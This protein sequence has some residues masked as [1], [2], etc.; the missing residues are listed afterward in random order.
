M[1]TQSQVLGPLPEHLTVV[2]WPD[3][4]ADGFGHA[5]DS[6]TWRRHG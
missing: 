4:V 5:P 1:P 3:A 6:P 2:A